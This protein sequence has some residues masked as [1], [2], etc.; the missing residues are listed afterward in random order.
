MEI[1]EEKE[2]IQNRK[3]I[4][5]LLVIAR[6]LEIQGFAVKGGIEDNSNFFQIVRLVGRHSPTLA[7]RQRFKTISCN[8]L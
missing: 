4:E 1:L 5:I 2:I 3:V 8:L 7:R 6:S